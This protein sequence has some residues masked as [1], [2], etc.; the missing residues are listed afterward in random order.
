MAQTS[1]KE[2]VQQRIDDLKMETERFAG[3]GVR[4]YIQ[5]LIQEMQIR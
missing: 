3:S 4:C 1:G 5:G 2:S